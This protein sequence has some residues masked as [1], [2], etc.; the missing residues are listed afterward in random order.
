M[1]NGHKLMRLFQFALL[2]VL[3]LL[4]G[5]K[6]KNFGF[7][8]TE[9]LLTLR[10]RKKMLPRFLRFEELASSSFSKP[11]LGEKKTLVKSSHFHSRV[12]RHPTTAKEIKKKQTK[13]LTR[14]R[15]CLENN[16]MIG[17]GG[18]SAIRNRHRFHSPNRCTTTYGETN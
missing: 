6:F 11:G 12:R 5:K 1:A 9:Q 4:G 17:G 14:P 18:L 2:L 15:N 7:I 3:V 10:L 16:E 8:E 13:K